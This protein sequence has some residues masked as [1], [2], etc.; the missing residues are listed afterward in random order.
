M[1]ITNPKIREEFEKAYKDEDGFPTIQ[2]IAT[3]WLERCVP[4]EIPPD[5]AFFPKHIAVNQQK[6]SSWEEAFNKKFPYAWVEWN[7][8][9]N[10]IRSLLSSTLQSYSNMLL[11]EV[12][13]MKG[14]VQFF[15]EKLPPSVIY[16]SALE[17]II[18][19]I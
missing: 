17:D 4:K 13:K 16:D 2:Y 7:E 9:K 10:F 1:T 3:W 11:A 6:E 5:G 14:K 19:I 12:E 18:K 15:D 8:V